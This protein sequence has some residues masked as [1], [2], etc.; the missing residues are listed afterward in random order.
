MN[1]TLRVAALGAV[2]G[3]AVPVAA[4]RPAA[5]PTPAAAPAP[6]AVAIG[7]QAPDFAVPGATRYGALA[8]P[9]RLS[10]YRGQTV[11]LAFFYKARTKG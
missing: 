4:Q 7:A 1:L 3:V 2:L 10:D 6:P 9:V 5:T 11:V 8:T